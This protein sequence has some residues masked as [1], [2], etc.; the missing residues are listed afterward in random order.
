MAEKYREAI[1]QEQVVLHIP[2]SNTKIPKKDLELFVVGEEDLKKEHLKM[3]DMYTDELFDIPGVPKKNRIVFGMSRLVCDVERFK[4]DEK[5]IMASRGMGVCYTATHDLKELKAVTPEHR[6]RMLKL[7]DRHHQKLVRTISDG[8]AKHGQVLLIDCHSFASERLPYEIE[9]E[10]KDEPRPDICLGFD[11]N[12][13]P[14]WLMAY[15]IREVE[16]RGYKVAVNYPFSGTIIPEGFAESGYGRKKL[17]SIMIE[18]NRK[19][20]MDEKTGEKLESFEK[21]K[22]D[23]GNIVKGLNT[24]ER[25]MTYTE[26]RNKFGYEKGNGFAEA[27]AKLNP[28]EAHAMIEANTSPTHVKACMWDQYR[29]IRMDFKLD[30]KIW[31]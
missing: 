29:K 11:R 4:D 8:I 9:S 26:F 18:V 10:G 30:L 24:R 2:H 17:M 5:E 12:Q 21:V 13:T 20:Y 3:T 31:Y 15:M 23:I 22:A 16:K 27:F 7:Y 1:T 28:F 25:L 6:E 19:L 14:A